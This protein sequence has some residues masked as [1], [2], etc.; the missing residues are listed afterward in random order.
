MLQILRYKA[1]AQETQSGYKE[2]VRL[3]SDLGH[4]RL[5]LQPVE[6]FLHSQVVLLHLGRQHVIVLLFPQERE[7]LAVMLDGREAEL[8]T[9]VLNNTS[10][11]S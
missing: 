1:L 6:V 3:P 4:L 8:G 5:G 10:C 9:R 7:E 2:Y 11:V